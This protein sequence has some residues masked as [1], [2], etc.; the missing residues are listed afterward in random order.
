MIMNSLIRVAAVSNRIKL[1]NLQTTTQTILS[2]IEQLKPYSPDICLFPA[3]ALTGSQLGSLAYHKSI[4]CNG[5]TSLLCYI[6]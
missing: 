1:G 2:I 4:I 5:L 6:S 3:Y